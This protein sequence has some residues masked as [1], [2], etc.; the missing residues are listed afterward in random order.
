[1]EVPRGIWK[2]TGLYAAAGE[3]IKVVIPSELVDKKLGVQIGC[4]TDNLSGKSNPARF[5]QIVRREALT[6]AETTFSS[7]FGGL[8]YI[9][10]PK[11]EG[12]QDF[13]DN[14]SISI[15]NTVPAPYF[16]LGETNLNEWRSRIRNHPAPWAE[17][18][19]STLIITVPS[20]QIRALE[21]PVELMEF[22]DN[23]QNANADL[24]VIPRERPYPERFVSDIQISYGLMHAGYPIMMPTSLSPNILTTDIA[25]AGGWGYYH[26]LGHNHDEPDYMPN[27]TSEVT[28][29]FWTLYVIEQVSDQTAREGFEGWARRAPEVDFEAQSDPSNDKNLNAEK[30]NKSPDYASVKLAMYLQLK[31]AFGWGTYK[32]VFKEYSELPADQKPS[33]SAQKKDQWCI[34]FS[35]ACG[36]NLAPFFDLWDFDVSDEAKAEV[37][38]LPVWM[39][40]Q[41]LATEKEINFHERRMK[42]DNITI[43][44]GTISP[45]SEVNISFDWTVGPTGNNGYCPGCIIQFYVG[46][47]DE[48]S[49]CVVSRQMRTPNFSQNGGHFEHTFTAPS[50]PGVYYVTH[51]FSLKRSCQ[52]NSSNHQNTIYNALALIHVQ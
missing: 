38:H 6:S 13:P 31:E 45:G 19:S 15:E 24:A 34:R 50:K 30:W 20:E 1:F 2:S 36:Y 22:W 43:T 3:S 28:P 39:P 41:N 42:Y 48:F 8:I 18:A 33:S 11:D 9:T 12:D 17:L 49:E 26:E 52:P 5:P 35:K 4:H 7:P 16:V 10:I 40:Y 27:G 29:N 32:K 37:E 25:N 44:P 23:I 46:I 14:V 21:D 51:S 47:Q